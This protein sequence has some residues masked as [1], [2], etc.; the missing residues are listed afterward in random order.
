MINVA[1]TL[2]SEG[3]DVL[4]VVATDLR[5]NL[6]PGPIPTVFLGKRSTLRAIF[7]LGRLIRQRKPRAIISALPHANNAAIISSLISGFCCP[8]TVSE[9]NSVRKP[10]GSM[11][12]GEFVHRVLS[13]ALYP[14]ARAVI[15][16]S[17]DLRND[18]ISG[19]HK[20]K[21]AAIHAIPNP[22]DISAVQE[23]AKIEAP[24]FQ[25]LDRRRPTILF[26]GRL[27]PQKNLRGLLR[28]FKLLLQFAPAN[29]VI[30]GEGELRMELQQ[31]VKDLDIEEF[32]LFAGYKANPL[33]YFLASEV[34]ALN[35]HY[36]GFPNVL[37]EALA[38]DLPIVATDCPTGPREIL[39]NGRWGT[40]VKVGDETALA[41]ALTMAIQNP[42]RKRNLSHRAQKY[43]PSVIANR[44][45]EV[46]L[47][48]ELNPESS[49][50]EASLEPPR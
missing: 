22:I 28:A 27:N 19:Y 43:Q 42:Q 38:L 12:K 16:V 8:V 29:L 39:D 24:D 18:I 33:P 37:L 50:S 21:I 34:L 30:V 35:S 44:Y 36:E 4:L 31:Q 26:V 13:H 41:K 5:K 23:L 47:G 32:V 48:Q 6:P 45:L 9:R 14:F 40:L 2:Q 25:S 15:C 49:S 17:E 7:G 10:R 11:G 20:V 3:H 46:A 1:T